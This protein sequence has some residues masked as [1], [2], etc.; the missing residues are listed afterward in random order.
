M[1]IV[2]R[3]LAVWDYDAMY[4]GTGVGDDS[5]VLY[6]PFPARIAQQILNV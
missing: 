3:S 6:V 4:A 5:K 2:P 1:G